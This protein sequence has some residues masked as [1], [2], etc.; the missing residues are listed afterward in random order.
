MRLKRLLFLCTA[1][2][3]FTTSFA[4]DF[5]Q[6]SIKYT[7]S[8]D[9]TVTLVD[10]KSTSGDVVIP[11]SV[12][13]GKNDYAVTVIEHNAFQGNNSITSVII[14][15]SVNSI[16]YSAF[17]ACKNLRSVT[18]ASSNANMQGY[19]YTDC[20]NLQSVTLSGSLQTIGYRSF[21]NTGL[22][23]LVLPANVKEIG[24]QAF[25]DCQHLTQVQF[26]SRLEVIKDHAFKQTGLIT[27]ELP[28]GV[29]EIGEWSFEGCQNLK[30]VVLPLR[31][32]ALGTGSFFHCTSLE[33]VVIP[34]N[35]TTFNDNTFNGCSRLSA[36]YYLGDNQPSVN[37]YTF[38]G[39][40]NKFNF[41]VKPSALANIRGVAYIS[42]K[43]KDSFP[44]QQRSKYATFS[45]D[46]AVDFASV[47]GLKAYIAK[48]VGENNSVNLLPITTAGAGTGLVIEA[49]PNVV[50]QL[51]LADNDTHY[52]DNALHV[53]TSEIANNATI[54]HK[55]DLTYLS[56]PVDLT[57]DKVRY[58]P[59]ST[60]TFTTKY[61]FPDGAKV[62]Y[63]HGN[64]VVA[65]ADISGKTSWT[66]KVPA[67]NFTGY[68]AEVYTT[69]GTTDNVY[70]T[71]GIDVST[72][73]GRFPRY[74]FVSHYD[75]SKTLDKVKGEVA[76][77][78]RYHMTGIQFYDWQWQHH[79]LFPQG[80][81]QWKDIGLR[82]VYK[83]SIDNYINQLHGVGS[84]CMFYDLI[85]GVTGNM[86]G[87]TPETPDNLDKD[88]VSSDWGWIDLHE[89]KGGG[90]DLH[91]Y[92]YPLGSWPSI[93]VMNPGNQNWVNYLAGSINKV[94]QNFGFDGY[95]IDQLGHQRD[96]YYVNLKSKKVNGKKVYTDGD[97]RNTNDFEGYFAN[98]INRMKA[99]NHNKYLVMNAASSFGGPNIVGTKNV[100]FGYNEMWG[101]D[102]YYWNYRKIIQDNRRNNGKN[103]F[104]TVFAAY[105]H[106]RNGRP[107][108]L[109]LSSALMGEATIFALGGSRIE[110]SGDHMLFTEYFPDDTRPMSSK[111]Q[112]SIIHYYDFLTAYENYLRDNN[113]E[114][115]VSMTMDGKQV[116]AWDLSNPD[117]SLNE[118]PEKQTIGPKP[119]MVN[120]YS[121]KKG[122]VTTIQLLNYSN[123]S[124]DNFNVRDLSETMPLPNVLNNKKIVLDDSQPVARIWV[125]SPDRLGGAPQEL[126]FTQ[127]SGKVAFTLPS[128]EY[129]TMV[130]VEHGQKSV[131]N[132]SRIKNYVLSGESFSLAQQNSL[133]A[134]DVYLSFPASLVSATTNVM[135]LKMVTEGIK[136]LTNV[137]G[138]SSD[139]YYTL[140]GIKLQKPSKGVYIHDGKT[141]V[142]K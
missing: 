45:S 47:N 38:A 60:V 98:F 115:T 37:Q 49:T 32:T 54:Q 51:R 20:S 69:V 126:D 44:Y 121:T 27:L 24:G 13:Y 134:G 111:L 59:N 83:S 73:W 99:D 118:H 17:N 127:S 25:Q 122:D 112:K 66:W 58:E 1:L 22:T 77:L 130:V 50:Y 93:Y 138:N 85:Y 64:K 82:N 136:N 102:D 34:G 9:K 67:D 18:D 36:V 53:A 90:Y 120:T 23:S 81:T 125:A 56:N 96:A 95:H 71:I 117:P 46:F 140:S 113:A 33:S 137:C 108:E 70:A 7:T 128:L 3:S 142:V 97:R 94:Y 101:G 79:I 4:D 41:Y 75:A 129:W 40:D 63:L 103:T 8:S 114:T 68:L 28:S 72:E 31:A 80:A 92:Q 21:A 26:D 29:N 15:S 132:S 19:E 107:G 88:G 89:K 43:V 139:D 6:N 91:Q 16:G 86:N 109:R 135:P 42:D 12:R 11:S 5:V 106:C 133:V 52:D 30:K 76:M 55:A 39:V 100:E 74:G 110:L 119:Y 10:G 61:A 48:G 105:L 123:V 78:N 141:I 57:T 87:N 124:R 35:I 84:K 65:T 104:N 2:L 131:D 62:R 116:V 14:P